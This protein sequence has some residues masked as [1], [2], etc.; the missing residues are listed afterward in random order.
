EHPAVEFV[1]SGGDVNKVVQWIV[2]SRAYRRS[3][4]ETA[5]LHERDPENRLY[6]RQSRFR[7]PAEMVRDNALAVSGLL[8]LDVGGPSAKPYQPAGYYRHLNFP[9]RDY[10]ADTGARQ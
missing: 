5:A 6:A 2:T 3:S 1:E 7:L 9:T 10:R 8:V 4:V